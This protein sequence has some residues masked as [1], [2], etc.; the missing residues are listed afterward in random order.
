MPV[1]HELRAAGITSLSGIAAALNT[2]RI[3]AARGG[4][5]DGHPGSPGAASAGACRAGNDFQI[6][7]TAV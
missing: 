7:V 4:G 2:R 5:M 3:P 6:A 1:L